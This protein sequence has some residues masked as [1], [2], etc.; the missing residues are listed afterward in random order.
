VNIDGTLYAG[1][2]GRLTSIALDPIEKKPLRRFFPGSRILSV[3]SYGCNFSCPF[4]QN[5]EI[6]SCDGEKPDTVYVSPE[7]LCAK[8]LELMPDGNIGLAYTYNEPFTAYEYMLHCARLCREAGL[9]NCIV[10]NGYVNR[11]PLMQILEYTDAMNI[12]LKSFEPDFYSWIG[13]RLERVMETIETAAKRC[14]VEVTTLIIPGKNDSGAEMERLSAWLAG[15]NDEIP[16][17]ITRFYPRYRMSGTPPA[18]P[19]RLEE[20]RALARRKLR[21]VY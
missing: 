5:H 17:H 3:G 10:T 16:L 11:E 7:A 4:C 6:S 15:V 14:H 20:L 18:N 12:D 9:K 1:S 13:G 8:G 2:Y 21:W 19:A